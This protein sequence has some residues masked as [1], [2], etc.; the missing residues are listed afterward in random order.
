MLCA[1]RGLLL[2]TAGDDGYV[3][4][5]RVADILTAA[6]AAAAA[7]ADSTSNAAA[8]VQPAA[9]VQLPHVQNALGISD[10]SLPAAQALAADQQQQQLFVGE[11]AALLDVLCLVARLCCCDLRCAA[12]VFG[13]PEQCAD[14]SGISGQQQQRVGCGYRPQVD[15]AEK[16]FLSS[17]I[18]CHCSCVVPS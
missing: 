5:W 7:P 8:A 1:E 2:A 12:T 4:I 16:L 6:A 9:A 11:C 10:G 14:V 15:T 17:S 3:R 13:A 18:H